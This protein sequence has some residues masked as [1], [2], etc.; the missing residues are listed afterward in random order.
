MN[1]DKNKIKEFKGY[2]Q[3]LK[4]NSDHLISQTNSGTPCGEYLRRYWHPVSLTS[5]VSETPEIAA[6]EMSEWEKRLES[7]K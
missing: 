7:K 5:D 4:P 6:P 2:K 3:T 1:I